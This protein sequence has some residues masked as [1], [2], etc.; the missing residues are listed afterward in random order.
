MNIV[1]I[2][3]SLFVLVCITCTGPVSFGFQARVAS[4]PDGDTIEVY[5]KGERF[6]TVVDLYGID[7]PEKQ[8]YFGRSAR[9]ETAAMVSSR[10][11]W[12][13]KIR[14]DNT[15]R[16]TA[17]VT[18]KEKNVNKT[19]VSKGWAWVIPDDCTQPFCDDWRKLE[20]KA[21]TKRIGL[22][23]APNPQPPWEWRKQ[24]KKDLLYIDPETNTP[25]WRRSP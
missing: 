6:R 21:R 14:E 22:W 4:I 16:I 12:V 11:I 25:V 3:Q 18:I 10:P 7:C 1:R 19:L 20:N 23:T 17:V 9:K 24:G 5:K 2:Y 8:Q 15:G 13:K